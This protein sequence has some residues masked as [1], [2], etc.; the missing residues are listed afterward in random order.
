LEE[1]ME[2]EVPN[3]RRVA[4]GRANRLLRGPLTEAGRQ[5]LRE[6]ARRVRPWE[7][8]TG[9]RTPVGKRRAA[10][11]GRTRQRGEKSVRQLRAE[12][13]D[14]AALVR[15]SRELRRALIAAARRNPS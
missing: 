13:A 1:I 2:P 6:A 8:A 3:P 7:N 15:L 10:E 4:A 12:L 9:P 14:V 5:R 11:N